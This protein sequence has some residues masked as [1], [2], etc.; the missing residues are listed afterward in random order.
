MDLAG[1]KGSRGSIIPRRQC[2]LPFAS[3]RTGKIQ[4]SAYAP[5]GKTRAS[6]DNSSPYEALTMNQPAM[7]QH[8]ISV[9]SLE[10][11]SNPVR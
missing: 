8:F 6:R 1:E 3:N 10:T 9:I 4:T 7:C 11:H 2:F 5:E